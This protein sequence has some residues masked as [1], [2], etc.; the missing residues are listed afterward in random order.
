MKVTAWFISGLLCGAVLLFLLM[1]PQRFAVAPDPKTLTGKEAPQEKTS[2]PRSFFND[3]QARLHKVDMMVKEMTAK[4]K[5][6]LRNGNSLL[7]NLVIL[8][9]SYKG[10]L[11]INKL[12]KRIG[13]PDKQLKPFLDQMEKD[14]W[15]K[16]QKD[17]YT[18]IKKVD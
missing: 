1:N 4:N 3:F 9:L 7:R 8:T 10:D 13:I 12:S 16:K 18:V 17:K 2:P 15:I 6:L 14:G 11:E 5:L